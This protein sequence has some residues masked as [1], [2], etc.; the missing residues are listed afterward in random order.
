MATDVR[1][2]AAG[3]SDD[4]RGWREWWL[5]F[6][7]RLIAKPSFQRWAAGFP[8]TRGVARRRARALFD[9]VAGFVYAQVLAACVRLN[10]FEI[11]AEG[12][13]S[14]AELAPRLALSEAAAH[15]LLKAAAALELVERLPDGRHGLGHLG[16]ALLGNPALPPMIAH[17]EMLYEDLAD[18]VALLRGQSGATRLAEFWAYGKGDAAPYSRLMAE[19]QS[20]VAQEILDAYPLAGHRRLMD[21]GGG[22]GA[23]LSAAGS[24]HPRL[25]LVLCDLPDV[26]KR[27]LRRLEA[28]GLGSRSTSAGRNFLTEPLPEGADIASLVRVL[29]DHDDADA[30]L[31]LRKVRAALPSG[32]VLLVAE[33]MSGAPGAGPMGDAYFGF[34]LL[35]MGSGR[36]RTPKEISGMLA[37]AGF[38]S[39][40]LRRTR[41]PL[42][43]QV[44]AARV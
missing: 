39:S 23:F 15:R 17:H 8:L 6:R 38:S 33:P 21:V 13:Q 5:D 11:L 3:K 31:I 18:P 34:Y 22:E 26:A 44:I 43:V 12:P 28:E 25:E 41:Q 7:N 37:E 16:A 27:G 30:M 35:A 4:P 24:R 19:S 36:P 29:H 42:V 10:L 9:L 32:G 20:L 40:R 14:L 2:V 1:P